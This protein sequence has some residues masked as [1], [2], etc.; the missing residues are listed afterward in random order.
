MTTEEK[1]ENCKYFELYPSKDRGSC[2]RYPQT[3]LVTV[4]TNEAGEV[5]SSVGSYAPVMLIEEFCGE[6]KEKKV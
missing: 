4:F 3:P 6:F 5:D 2:S 1:C